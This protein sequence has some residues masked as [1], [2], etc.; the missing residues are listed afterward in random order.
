MRFIAIVAA[1]HFATALA[2]EPA[3]KPPV[4]STAK[5][6]V[7]TT[8]KPPVPATAKPPVPITAKPPVPSGVDP[9]GILITL[10]GPGVDYTDPKIAARLARD[11][12]GELIGWDLVDNDRRP[13]SGTDPLHRSVTP[14]APGIIADSTA[15]ARLAVFRAKSNDPTSLALTVAMAASRPPPILIISTDGP[16]PSPDL[17]AAISQRLPDSL[18]L[19]THNNEA[20]STEKPQATVPLPNVVVI[21]SFDKDRQ[22]K[23]FDAK[24]NAPEL[25][26]DVS[27]WAQKLAGE[28]LDTTYIGLPSDAAVAQIAALAARILAAE[29]ALKG[30]ELKTRI[31]SITEPLPEGYG[32]VATH[33]WIPDPMKHYPLSAVKP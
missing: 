11:G 28:R 16:N 18:V 13:Y 9:G 17:L 5:P 31:L 24:S 22:A 3:G 10:V 7:P 33:G 23:T 29:P 32:Y 2:A 26:M 14:Q 27:R 30:P 6:A 8:A 12:E 1:L 21:A 15:S 25:A 19:A 4:P 20:S